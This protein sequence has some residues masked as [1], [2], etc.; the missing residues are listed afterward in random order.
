MFI[1]L[2]SIVHNT[3]ASCTMGVIRGNASTM[4]NVLRRL[5]LG[6]CAAFLLAVSGLFGVQGVMAQGGISI[7]PLI[8]ELEA[9][10]GDRIERSVRV[11]NQYSGAYT[12]D[13][14]SFDVDIESE[15]HNVRFLP[16]ASRQNANRSLAS[17]VELLGEERFPLAVEEQRDVTFVIDV[18]ETVVPGDYYSSLNFYYS[19]A[20]HQSAP[21]A[22][23]VRQ[24]LG[25]LVL[26]TVTGE[27]APRVEL[28]FSEPAVSR[29]GQDIDFEIDFLNDSLRYVNLKPVLTLISAAGD[30]L[31][32][33]VGG[34]KRV[35]P[36]E[37]TRL[38]HQLSAGDAVLEAT[39]LRYSF[40]D[41][42]G[43]HRYA[44]GMVQLDPVE[45]H[46]AAS[47]EGVTPSALALLLGGLA[48]VLLVVLI[49]RRQAA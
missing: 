27:S 48:V 45:L 14:E 43:E 41:R 11:V 24:S 25:V 19:P 3:S 4:F 9:Q 49:W 46:G 31:F 32:E 40:W 38:K 26:L 37:Q 20:Q 22:V 16:E 1:H 36:G 29:T 15:S 30:T 6:L 42:Q 5:G 10:A 2:T 33:S 23:R 44:E 35:F 18:P 7:T 12:V 34:A 28:S 39:E 47:R 8:M 21:G 13:F 17:W